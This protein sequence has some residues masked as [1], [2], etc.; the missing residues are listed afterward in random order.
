MTHLDLKK[1]LGTPIFSFNI[2]PDFDN[3]ILKALIIGYLKMGGYQMQIT[4]SSLETLLEAYEN[5]DL[6]RNLVVRVGGYSEYFCNLTNELK[7]MI[8]SRTI[9]K[10]G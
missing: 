7:K 1:A 5:P 8:I 9:Q 4:C 10:M 2:N 6:H 3:N